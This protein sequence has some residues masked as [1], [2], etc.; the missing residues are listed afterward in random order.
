MKIENNN[1]KA[2]VTQILHKGN[3]EESDSVF[4]VRDDAKEED[5]L[6]IHWPIEKQ[7]KM[8][9]LTTNPE[10]MADLSVKQNARHKNLMGML[11][12]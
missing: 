10:R 9:Y 8:M 6:Y 5:V 11:D 12:F 3:N 4:I 7:L 1:K 2:Y